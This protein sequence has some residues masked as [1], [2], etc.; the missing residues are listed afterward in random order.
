MREFTRLPDLLSDTCRCLA[1]TADENETND[2]FKTLNNESY[3]LGPKGRQKT[4][5]IACCIEKTPE[6]IC[7]NHHTSTKIPILFVF[8]ANCTLASDFDSYYFVCQSNLDMTKNAAKGLNTYA[9]GRF[10]SDFVWPGGNIFF[11]RTELQ[12]KGRPRKK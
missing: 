7:V 8:E 9:F 1:Q 12:R 3:D 4:T 6:G 5:F 2:T 10:L 11:L